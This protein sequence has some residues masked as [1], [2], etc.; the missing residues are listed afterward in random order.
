MKW[1]KRWPWYA[2]GALAF[3]AALI[4]G[5][6]FSVEGNR[7]RLTLSVFDIGQG[8]AVFLTAPNGNQ[9]LIDGG[10]DAA[11][12]AKLGG[13]MPFWDRSIDLVILTH[14]HADHLAGLLRVVER[15]K[16]GMVLESGV[17]HSIPEY[18]LWHDALAARG[19]PVVV[20]ERGEVIRVAS[21]LAISVLAPFRS[22][23]GA[24]PR[25]VHDASIVLFLRHASST[26]LLMAD[27][28][29]ATERELLAAGDPVES[30][31]RAE[32]LKVGHH[33]SKTSTIEGFLAAVGPRLAAISAGRRNRYG[34]PA[35]EILDR[36]AAFGVKV[37]RT[38][39]DGTLTFV[40]DGKE[41]MRLA[42]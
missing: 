38:D 39:R 5:A 11:V 2:L 18:D 21:D 27:A 23:A 1:R 14:P 24:S 30:G 19:I 7:G 15:Y 25:N 26:A 6:V 32:F 10:P 17:N 35:Q 22:F 20:A 13:V 40:S 8:D 29:M 37:Y 34:H 31:I 36:L 16:I 33:G 3:V 41:F 12:L 4:W 42:P 28:E 9:V